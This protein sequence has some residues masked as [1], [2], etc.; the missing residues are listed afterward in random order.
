MT[1]R[2]PSDRSPSIRLPNS[3]HA[4]LGLFQLAPDLVHLNHGS[5]GAVPREVQAEQDRWRALIEAD[6]T[7][8]FQDVYPGEIRRMADVA[9]T[10]F[11]GAADD[12]VFCENAT[13][14]VSSVLASFSLKPGDEILTTSHAYGAVTKAMRLWADRRG[15]TLQI[16]ELPSLL[17][18]DDQILE[19]VTAA[20]T[21]RTRLLVVDHITSPTA[22]IFPVERLARAARE[23]GIAVLIDGAHAPG[24]VPLDVPAIGADWYTGNAHKW[25]FAP[26]GCGL[27][28]THPARQEITRPSVL[29]HGTEQGY[30]QAFDWIGTRDATPWLSFDAA[31]R[32]HEMLGGANLIARNRALAAEAAELLSDSLSAPISAPVSMRGAM[33]SLCLD[34]LGGDPEA[35]RA[36]RLSLRKRGIVAPVSAFAGGLWIR[37]SA[38]IYNE[39]GDYR[40]CARTLAEI[41]PVG[42][43]HS[44]IE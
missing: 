16:A 44:R 3:G 23:R 27:L 6:A 38:Q 1:S 22:V 42:D 31:S 8:F 39:I 5:Y 11:G 28:W 21:P 13:A 35:A 30:T 7:G 40:Q 37:I 34:P 4:A 10:R 14:A 20:I 33:A 18:C 32:A 24:Q 2:S 41:R 36:L 12:W 26:K 25:F 15:A 17:D 19:R 43:S 29:S 9:A